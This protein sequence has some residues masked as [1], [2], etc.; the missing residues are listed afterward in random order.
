[1][2][3]IIQRIMIWHFI[4]ESDL[5]LGSDQKTSSKK[6]KFVLTFFKIRATGNL[7]K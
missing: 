2:C 7:F 6:K 4:M 5:V 3:T 1:M